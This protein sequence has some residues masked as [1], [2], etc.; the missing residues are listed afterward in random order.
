MVLR[1]RDIIAWKIL[2]GMGNN[3]WT[4]DILGNKSWTVCVWREYVFQHPP[5]NDVHTRETNKPPKT[6]QVNSHMFTKSTSLGTTAR[7]A[8]AARGLVKASATFSAEGRR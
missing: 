4:C 7:N 6:K 2:E 1:A 8:G 5:S 3:L